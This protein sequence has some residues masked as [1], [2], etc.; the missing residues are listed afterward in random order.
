MRYPPGHKQATRRRIVAAAGARFRTQGY[1]A[2]G[3]DEVMEAAGLTPGGF[4]AHFR[5]KRA[6]L[7]EALGTSAGA[8]QATLLAGLDEVEGA[9]LLRAVVGRYLSRTHRDHAGAGCPLPSLAAEVARDGAAPRLAVQEYLASIT[10][11][12]GPRTPPA[13]GLSPE[14]RVLATAALLA[15]ALLLARAVPDPGLSD[16]ILR[17]ARRLAVPA[18]AAADE[19]A[20]A[21]APEGRSP[22][23]ARPAGPASAPRGMPR[24]TQRPSTPRRTR[25]AR[26]RR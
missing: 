20:A 26:S 1:A 21:R 11:A 22:R 4:Y 8:M 24:S 16:R 10:A 18:T 13:P 17:A 25:G 7:A 15:G 9:P 14:D 3:V 6:L 23:A 2:T 12:L 5:S 19:E